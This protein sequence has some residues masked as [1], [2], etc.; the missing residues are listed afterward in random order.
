MS[1]EVVCIHLLAHC[2]EFF[3]TGSVKNVQLCD[4]IVDDALFGIRVFYRWVIVCDKITL[5]IHKEYED[6]LEIRLLN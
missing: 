2:T 3:L 4:F 6:N 1:N 5:K